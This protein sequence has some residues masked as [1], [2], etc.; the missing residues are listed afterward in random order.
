[1]NKPDWKDAPDWA[2]WLIMHGPVRWCWHEK[3]PVKSGRG[4]CATGRFSLAFREDGGYNENWVDVFERRPYYIVDANK[5]VPHDITPEFMRGYQCRS[6]ELN[7][8]ENWTREEYFQD[9]M[10]RRVVCAANRF[11]DGLI[12]CGA[13]HWDSLMCAQATALGI[14]GGNEEQGFIDQY[15]VFMDRKEAMQ[16]AKDAGQAIDIRFGCGGDELTLYSEGLY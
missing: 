6:Q 8:H 1:M 5:K 7:K 14:K 16:V 15:G 2:N 4:W 13:R 12:L 10:I 11:P 9:R 3:K